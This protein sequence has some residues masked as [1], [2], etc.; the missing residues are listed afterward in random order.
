LIELRA[1]L[2]RALAALSPVVRRAGYLLLGYG[3][4]PRTPPTR[5]ILTPKQRYL[6][7][8]DAVGRTWLRFGITASD[9]LHV[10][11]SR[12]ELVPTMNLLN[13]LSGAL[14]AVSANSS[15]YG[16]RPGAYASGREGL[17]RELV[18]EPFRHGAVPRPFR[19]LED[20]V[21]WACGFRCLVL[22]A[23]KGFRF[24]LGTFADELARS[25]PDLDTFLYHEHYLW[26][27]ARPRVRLG[28]LEIRPACQ[29]PGL[30]FGPA[31]FALGLAQARA[32]VW[33]YLDDAL[34][35]KA[36]TSLLTYRRRAIR[37]GLR[38]EEPVPGFLRTLLDLAERGLADR[39]FGEERMLLPIRE[40]VEKGRGPAD[41][42]RD[43]VRRG[44]IDALV[45]G[46]ALE[47]PDD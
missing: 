24:P 40:R 35:A 27:S 11:L 6:A 39:G 26:P 38:A 25:Q 17:M 16:G 43:L 31:A 5:S 12:D 18:A 3:I 44:G 36:W 42:A 4:Q 30:S 13:G 45:A 22:P 8:L 41:V 19:D 21:R 1:D 2:D 7:F 47:L 14:I 15:V 37:M 32:E 34:G 20:Y 9:Q 10:A 33:A 28:T 46:L 23:G 29:Q